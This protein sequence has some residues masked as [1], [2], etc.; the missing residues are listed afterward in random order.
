MATEPLIANVS[1][2]AFLVA[3]QR[4]VEGERPDPLFRDPLAAKL[5]GEH[6]RA[7]LDRLPRRALGVWLVPVRTV[8]IDDLILRSIEQGVD[9]VLNLG[10][11]LDTRPYRMPLP[12]TLRWIEVD[13]A[14]IIDLKESRLADDEPRCVLERVKLDLSDTESRR[15]V[16]EDVDRRSNNVLVLT[17]GVVPY[18]SLDEVGALADDL[19]RMPHVRSWIVDYFSPAALRFRKRMRLNFKNAPFKFDPKDW[20]AFFRDHGWTCAEKRFLLAEGK[21][22]GRPLPLSKWRRAL[23]RMRALFSA[24]KRKDMR[25]FA[26]YFVMVPD[27]RPH[28]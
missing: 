25:E 16:F 23:A 17:E 24:K 12:K 8:V 2:T 5:A 18:L 28:P 7:L 27:R 9:T 19:S 6:G 10:A 15:R 20:F 14:P 11:G 22:L 13:F 4:S 26:G 21:R 1:D 3:M